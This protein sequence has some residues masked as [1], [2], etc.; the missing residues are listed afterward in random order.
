VINIKN[1]YGE[2]SKQNATTM[3]KMIVN[4][5]IFCYL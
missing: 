5:K 4:P 3:N 2:F 1:D